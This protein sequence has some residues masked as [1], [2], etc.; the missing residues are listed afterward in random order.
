[1]IRRVRDRVGV[2]RSSQVAKAMGMSARTLYRL[3]ASGK[4]PEPM[5]NP[6]NGYRMWSD[7]DLTMLREVLQ[8]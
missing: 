3:L 4:I 1:M 6:A 8:R 5:R 2:Y 7:M